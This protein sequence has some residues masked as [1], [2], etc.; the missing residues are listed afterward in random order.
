MNRLLTGIIVISS[1][2]NSIGV[3]NTSFVGWL[4]RACELHNVLERNYLSSV[5]YPCG[6]RLSNELISSTKIYVE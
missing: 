2:Y 5:K 6:V 3:L 1:I 4:N